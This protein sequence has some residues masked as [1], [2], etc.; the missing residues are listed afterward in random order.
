VS[1]RPA[2]LDHL[3]MWLGRFAAHPAFFQENW[4][5]LALLTRNLPSAE[6]LKARC[7]AFHAHVLSG[8][9][10][11]DATLDNSLREALTLVTVGLVE[12]EAMPI[13]REH[14][15]LLVPSPDSG[16]SD[17]QRHASLMKAL[18]EI[19]RASYDRIIAQW[20]TAHRRRRNLW[21]EMANLKLPDLDRRVG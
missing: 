1:H 9:P 7:P 20:K 4:H 15:H 3:K 2:F 11:L 13:W 5:S 16:G 19:N 12:V 10:A 21:A 14:L 17:Y 6:Q 8:K 18:C